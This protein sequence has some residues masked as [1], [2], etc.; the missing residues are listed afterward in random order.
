M[1]CTAMRTFKII[2][3]SVVAAVSNEHLAFIAAVLVVMRVSLAVWLHLNCVS[4]CLQTPSFGERLSMDVWSH[5]AI[6]QGVAFE[7]VPVVRIRR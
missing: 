1:V 2:Q 3:H 5:K 7:P 6:G 4:N